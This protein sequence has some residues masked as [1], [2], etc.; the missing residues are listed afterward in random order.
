[1]RGQLDRGEE[2]QPAEEMPQG[3]GIRDLSLQASFPSI[4]LGSL[5]KVLL[6]SACSKHNSGPYMMRLEGSNQTTCEMPP[7]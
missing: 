3:R 5:G 4:Q 2:G 1:M 6:L 7:P